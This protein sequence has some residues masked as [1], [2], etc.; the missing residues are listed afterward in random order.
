MKSKLS[1]RQTPSSRD[2]SVRV[3]QVES[4]SGEGN[5][6]ASFRL[7]P[8]GL[9]LYPGDPVPNL[10]IE[11]VNVLLLVSAVELHT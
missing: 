11:D 8:T 9:S 6:P 10:F 4:K 5:P 7:L 3:T 1:T 2:H